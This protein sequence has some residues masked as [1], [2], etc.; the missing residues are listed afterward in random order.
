MATSKIMNS[1]SFSYTTLLDK[2]THT[3]GLDEQSLTDS[4]SKYGFICVLV[5]N[6]NGAI[7]NSVTIP[8]TEFKSHTSNSNLLWLQGDTD[9]DYVLLK[10]YSSNDSKIYVQTAGTAYVKVLGVR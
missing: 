4:L 7:F 6:N 1:F 3:T 2:M 5:E 10:A 9:S 8:V